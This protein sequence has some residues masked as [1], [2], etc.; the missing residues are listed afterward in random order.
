[1]NF[2]NM[3]SVI[4]MLLIPFMVSVYFLPFA[5]AHSFAS[6]IFLIACLTDWLDGYLARKLEQ[7]TAFGAFL[8]PVADKILVTSAIVLI[9]GHAHLSWLTLPSMIIIGREIAVSA[10]REWMAEI[11]ARTSVAVSYVGK[12]K[13]VFQ[14]IALLFLLYYTPEITP[15]WFLMLG[16]ILY[17]ASA[18]LTVWSMMM[19]F[20]AAWPKLNPAASEK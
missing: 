9:L 19:Y 10:L 8:D 1:M 7:T 16:Y 20:R 17:Y 13:T 4:R 18:A 3:I 2:P 12:V 15:D 5:G 11:G 6:T 14:M